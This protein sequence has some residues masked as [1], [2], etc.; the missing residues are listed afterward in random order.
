[1]DEN[2]F[3]YLKTG[4]FGFITGFIIGYAFKKLSKFLVIIVGLILIC[5]Q[6]LVYNGIISVNWAILESTTK[7]IISNQQWSLEKLKLV[8]LVNLPFA[9]AAGIGFLLGLKKG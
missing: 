9:G 2:F 4:G 6:L 7:D 5:T 3:F 1:M 8:L